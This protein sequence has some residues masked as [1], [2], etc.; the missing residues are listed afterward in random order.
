MP[1]IEDA[2]DEQMVSAKV[3][4]ELARL[5]ND[6]LFTSAFIAPVAV[7]F[8]AWLQVEATDYMHAG[9][10]SLAILTVILLNIFSGR[11][12]SRAAREGRSIE[13]WL[14]VQILCSA[15]LGVTWGMA[16]W[17]VWAPDQFLFY[18][19]TL[20][21]LVGVS[22]IFMVILAP[23]RR[24]MLWFST[25]M[26]IL[27]LTQMLFIKHPVVLELG[28]GWVIMIGIQ[29]WYSGDLRKELV[30]Q[31]DNAVRNDI[32]V[33]RLKL[34]GEELTRTNADLNAAMRQLN[35]LV[36]VDQLTGASSRRHIMDELERQVAMCARHGSAVSVIMLDLDHFKH[37]NDRYGHS[38]GDH[39][40]RE[41]AATV[42]AQ[43]RDGDMLGRIG[44]EEFLVLLPMTHA[45][46]AG[47][48]AERLR[49]ALASASITEG[50]DTF[51]IPASLGV[52]ELR[53]NED[54]GAWLRRVDAALYQAKT[55]GRNRV[56]EAAP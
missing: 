21:V 50:G 34:V 37:I 39:A 45:E 30:A 12:F 56:V 18:I 43:L 29:W 1:S 24:A 11:Q 36:T 14:R 5:F 44:G 13:P 47:V 32:L 40:L 20:S 54:A 53:S 9:I 3:H 49:A 31:F 2:F 46:A 7:G 6:R 52:A 8:V 17:F 35:Q 51:H 19:T 4:F 22:F 38:V 42:R 16:A 48:L 41:A 33:K 15:L 23:M 27:P 55:T 10:W 28:V 26:A 25:G